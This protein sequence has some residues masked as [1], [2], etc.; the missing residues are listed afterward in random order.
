MTLPWCEG[1][2]HCV[3]HYKI[4]V[5]NNSALLHLRLPVKFQR[6]HLENVC[7]WTFCTP[8]IHSFVPLACAECDDSLPFSGAS[9]IPLCY[10]PFPSTLFHQLVF[11]HPSFHSVI[12]FLIDLLASLFPNLFLPK[13]LWEICSHGFFY[14][15]G[16]LAHCKTFKLKG[17]DFWSGFTPLYD[18]LSPQFPECHLP[19]FEFGVSFS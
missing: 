8:S 5:R 9:S 19:W 1:E 14:V 11:H 2:I 12:Y 4:C 3:Y 16:G 17:L 15:D 7:V 18:L 10:T 13:L 6:L